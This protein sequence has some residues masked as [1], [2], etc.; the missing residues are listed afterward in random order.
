MDMMDEERER[1]V[2]QRNITFALNYSV[3]HQIQF[4]IHILQQLV[5]GVDILGLIVCTTIP[6]QKYTTKNK[7]CDI[8]LF[9][10]YLI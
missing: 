3:N 10:I 8:I 7:E 9:F 5:A 1:R 4:N 6:W 2:I